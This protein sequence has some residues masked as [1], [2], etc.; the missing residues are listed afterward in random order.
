MSEE[1][2]K[3]CKGV[4]QRQLYE[5]AK[6]QNQQKAKAMAKLHV[7]PLIFASSRKQG[8]QCRRERARNTAALKYVLDP[9]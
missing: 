9:Y 8:L 7:A 5:T 1:A 2:S 3:R 6:I 4:T